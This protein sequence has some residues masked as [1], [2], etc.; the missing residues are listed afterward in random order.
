MRNPLTVIQI[1]SYKNN[2]FSLYNKKKGKG[3][4]QNQNNWIDYKGGGACWLE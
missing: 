1:D 4:K 2:I 3:N